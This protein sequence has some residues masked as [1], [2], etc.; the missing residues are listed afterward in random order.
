[1]AV[2]ETHALNTRAAAQSLE[3]LAHLQHDL[4]TLILLFDLK[5]NVMR[6]DKRIK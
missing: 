1:M 2:D 3:T 5:Y 6:I 4:L